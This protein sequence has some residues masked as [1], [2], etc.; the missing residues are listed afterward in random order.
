VPAS[1]SQTFSCFHFPADQRPLAPLSL[2]QAQ[3][4]SQKPT[5]HMSSNL[6]WQ[7]PNAKLVD[8]QGPSCLPGPVGTSGSDFRFEATNWCNHNLL[9]G[10]VHDVVMTLLTS[11][12]TR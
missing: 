8:F 7:V 4:L 5:A 6:S 9:R 2:S 1:P 12:F 11:A 3:T 10:D